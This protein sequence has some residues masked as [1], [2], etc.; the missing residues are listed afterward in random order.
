MPG[1]QSG[2]NHNFWWSIN[3]G[4]IHFTMLSTEHPYSPGSP[5]YMWLEEVN[6]VEAYV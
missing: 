3:Y 2:G 1:A 4:N 6:I 5:Q